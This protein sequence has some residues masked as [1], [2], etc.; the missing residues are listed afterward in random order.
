[1]KKKLLI[2]TIVL[3]MFS[4]CLIRVNAAISTP[5]FHVENSVSAQAPKT[6][7]ADNSTLHAT[8]TDEFD[9]SKIKFLPATGSTNITG[10]SDLRKLIIGRTSSD[11]TA[12]PITGNNS[13]KDGLGTLFGDWFTAYCLDK[14]KKYPEYGLFND[15]GPES[16]PQGVTVVSNNYVFDE[17]YIN[18]DNHQE[19]QV[20]FQVALIKAFILMDTRFS[21][22]LTKGYANGYTD[23]VI[24]YNGVGSTSDP[25]SAGIKGTGVNIVPTGT[26]NLNDFYKYFMG[27]TTTAATAGV[28]YIALFNSD[29]RDVIVFVA[30]DDV[31]DAIT[32]PD[33]V[34][35]GLAATKFDYILGT[36][37]AA[38]KDYVELNTRLGDLAFPKYKASN[39]TAGIE[40]YERILWI[41]ENTYPTVDVDQA[42]TLAGVKV[43]DF[44]ANVKTLYGTAVPDTTEGKKTYRE[45]VVYGLVQYAIW[46][47]AGAKF[48]NVK[49]GN[50]IADADTYKAISA[51]YKYLIGSTIPTGY[52]GN[53][54]Y[55]KGIDIAYPQKN[56]ELFKE[57]TNAY[58]YGPFSASYNAVV[59]GEENIS[60]AL[61]NNEKNLIQI[62]DGTF[63]PITSVKKDDAFYISVDKKVEIKTKLEIEA[64]LNLNHVLTFSP[65]GDRGRVYNSINTLGQNAI[66]GGKV[67]DGNIE[68]TL[69]MTIQ[70]NPNTGVQNIALLLMVTLV[71][72]TLGY[73]VLSYKQKP[74]TLNQ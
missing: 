22:L 68:G 16:Y 2:S 44:D 52:S 13:A 47:S 64:N 38:D 39:N 48:N 61:K 30:N 59:E 62:V 4:V 50:D 5:L 27:D 31:K 32:A 8:I 49:L 53:D 29:T 14:D 18:D 21:S 10:R 20:L 19:R 35:E 63:K 24:Y 74:L 58:I 56:K 51:F 60:L 55:S 72:F 15:Y 34:F 66:S 17:T 37:T 9:F 1:M 7:P 26:N 36:A 54:T 11:V 45:N 3:F 42:L 67:T 28:E 33:A 12:H 41:V 43:E 65:I 23:V 70:G 6:V 69:K 25:S 40:N 46:K 71:A 57:T 73:L